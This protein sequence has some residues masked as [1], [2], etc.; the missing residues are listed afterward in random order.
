MSLYNVF[1]ER[2][3]N[4]RPRDENIILLIQENIYGVPLYIIYIQAII[5]VINYNMFFHGQMKLVA[6]SGRMNE[7]TCK[8][9]IRFGR[10][11]KQV[12]DGPP[13]M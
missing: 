4:S 13:Y 2:V 1:A 12:V 9:N 8:E 3:L 5:H 6:N 10:V 11:G 7:K